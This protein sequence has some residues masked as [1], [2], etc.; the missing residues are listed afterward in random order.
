MKTL[1]K[2][3]ALK[4]ESAVGD[5]HH[6][7]ILMQWIESARQILVQFEWLSTN[8]QEFDAIC[9]RNTVPVFNA[10]WEAEHSDALTR[11]LLI[12]CQYLSAAHDAAEGRAA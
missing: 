11:L 3:L 12:Q 7:A 9:K 1:S 10:P 8:D 4:I 2:D 5:A 6:I